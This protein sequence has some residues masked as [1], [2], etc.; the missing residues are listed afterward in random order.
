MADHNK[1]VLTST[2]TNFVSELDARFD[3]LAVG[4]DPA[5]TTATNVPTGSL[6]WNSALNKDQKWNGAAW[7]DKSATYVFTAAQVTSLLSSG[8]VTLSLGNV[9]IPDASLFSFG[10]GTTNIAG[11][12]AAQTINLVI[13]GTTRG[14]ASATGFAV[15]GVLTSSSTINGL[16]LSSNSLSSIAATNLSIASGTTGILS[17]DSGT[18][19]A[20]NLGT[21]ATAK[22]ITIG[23][24]TGGTAVNINTGTG[25]TTQTAS[26][27][28][29]N[30]VSGNL[31][32]NHQ[33]SGTPANGIGVG[34]IFDQETTA[35]T[36]RGMLVNAIT[37]DVTSAS[38]DFDFVVSLMAAGAVAAEKFRVTSVGNAK[39]SGL[40]DIS[41]AADTATAA[42]HYFVETSTDG[43]VR[44]KTLANVQSEIVTTSTVAAAGS[45]GMQSVAKTAAYT[46]IS[47]DRGDVIQCTDTWTLSLTAAV[48]LGNGFTI[49]VINSGTGTITID[50]N[51]SELVDTLTTKIL[52]P[53]QS[54][55]LVCDGASW[56][57]LGLS[58][59][60]AKGGGADEIFY[61]NN[62]LISNPYTLIAG[63]NAGTFGPITI[64][65]GITVTI[66]DGAT[67]SIV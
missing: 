10:A 12:S 53:G 37:T 34:I 3:D 61:E 9:I 64:A 25:A 49:G 48:T 13:N 16:N 22:T 50:P 35:G 66:S 36:K 42:T 46:V 56:R 14:A 33:T 51:A 57:T 67:W 2:Y 39:A 65:D 38:E 54:C 44:P 20:I 62:Q 55:L 24:A 26:T 6:R 59:G 60:G 40:F 63:K 18:T 21:S 5:V 19:G 30:T 8:N 31:V 4:L 45:L 23:N 17:L 41:A 43:F 11:S 7:V 27:A 29:T 58:G 15:T 52:S 28:L 1:P 47:T 32:L